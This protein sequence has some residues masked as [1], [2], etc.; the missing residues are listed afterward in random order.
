MRVRV[1]L[2]GLLH[3]PLRLAFG[4]LMNLLRTL[5]ALL[6]GS[7]AEP[8]ALVLRLRR[9]LLPMLLQLRLVLHLL[10]VH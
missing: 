1:L 10:S 7:D 9:Q 6:V 4:I 5:A 8:M 3:H 2:L